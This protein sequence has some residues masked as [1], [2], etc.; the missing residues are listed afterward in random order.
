MSTKITFSKVYKKTSVPV[1]LYWQPKC[2]YL[3]SRTLVLARFGPYKNVP[4]DLFANIT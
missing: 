2:T 1:P 3:E 4:F